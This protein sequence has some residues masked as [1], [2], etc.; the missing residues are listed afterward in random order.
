MQGLK[1]V[2]FGQSATMYK[3]KL[4]FS[5]NDWLCVYI[6]HSCMKTRVKKNPVY[7]QIYPQKGLFN[8]QQ[9]IPRFKSMFFP[10]IVTLI[11]WFVI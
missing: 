1:E 8:F 2:N 11:K 7:H 10:V 3:E 4:T 9:F 5:S 6:C